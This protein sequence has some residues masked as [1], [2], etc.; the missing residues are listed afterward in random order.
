MLLYQDLRGLRRSF[1]VALPVSRSQV[2]WTSL[3]V[4]G[5][6]SCHV[7]PW[8][9]GSVNSVPSSFHD[10]PVARS[11]TID[12]RLFCL[13]CWS[14]I[15]RL[16]NTPIIGRS[17]TIVASSWID[18]LAG[19]SGVNIL[20]M[21]PCFWANAPS[22]AD[23]AITNPPTATKPR[24]RCFIAVSLPFAYREAPGPFS[25]GSLALPTTEPCYSEILVLSLVSR[26]G[27]LAVY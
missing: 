21:P 27:H 5:L 12:V 1:S 2:H 9:S 3:A 18:M 6:P 8:R 25:V 19:L 4:K 11:G 23:I 10:Q 15:T 22:A 7:T 17:E 26:R 24:T 16:L 14:N 13:T 20:R